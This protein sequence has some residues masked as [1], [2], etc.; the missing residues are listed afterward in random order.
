MGRGNVYIGGG[1]AHSRRATMNVTVATWNTEVVAL[2]N[3]TEVQTGST[4]VT[5]YDVISIA[6]ETS[7]TTKYKAIGMEGA[8][9][10]YVYGVKSDGT[11]GETWTQ[12][13]KPAMAE[14]G[15]PDNW[16]PDTTGTFT[17]DP[18]NK[19]IYFAEADAEKLKEFNAIACAYTYKSDD[20]AQTIMIN[21][22]GIPAVVLVTAYGIARSIC[23][24][25]LYT[26]VIEGQAQIDGNWNF[27]LS[28]DGEPAVQSLNMEFVK[29]CL[30][31]TLYSFKVITEDEAEG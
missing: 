1:F 8:E 18:Q 11:Y 17:Y 22:D 7:A 24:G 6:G 14:N 4:E 26:A 25:K 15:T 21:S 9:I 23:D 3:G 31:N 12:G 16:N 13:A 28:A 19:T 29:G 27:D 30:N 10:T 5:Y 2:Q 20:K